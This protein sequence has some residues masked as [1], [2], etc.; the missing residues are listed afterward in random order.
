MNNLNKPFNYTQQGEQTQ[1]ITVAKTYLSGVFM[2]M[3]LALGITAATAYLFATTESLISLLY[4]PETG[5]M[6]I[7]GWV[8]MLAPLGLVL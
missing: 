8:I 4:N 1:T 5:G 3:F 6:S 7:L 2:W